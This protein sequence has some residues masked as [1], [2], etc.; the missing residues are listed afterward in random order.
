M[1]NKPLIVLLGM[2]GS[3][4]TTLG[5]VL[6]QKLNL[7]FNDLDVL[8]EEQEGATISQLFESRGEA[9]FRQQESGLLKDVLS[10]TNA[11]VLATGGGTP[12]FFDNMQYIKRLAQSIYLE[13][14][15]PL[16][17]QRLSGQPGQRPLLTGVSLDSMS[18]SL[19]EKFG[20]RIFYYQQ[21]DIK[22]SVK[23]AQTAEE[24]ALQLLPLLNK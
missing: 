21:A 23:E 5:N 15:W 24:L 6:A 16:L 7:S 8:L 17:A 3:G 2:P 4:K 18:R 14:P 11:M 9:Y 10:S 13:V 12:C 1:S 20:W 19:E 22:L